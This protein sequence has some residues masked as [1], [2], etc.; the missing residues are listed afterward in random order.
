VDP[1]RLPRTV[2]PSRYDLR[3][4]PDLVTHTFAGEETIALDVA[5]PTAEVVL[6]TSLSEGGMPN[7]LLEA[8]AC[9]RPILATDIP[10]NRAAVED[11]T[12]GFLVADE[13]RFEEAARR[14]ATDPELRSRQGGA[15]RA[16]M[17]AWPSP[18]DE[19]AAYAALYE[20]VL[21][22]R[23]PDAAS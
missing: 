1:Y 16:R 18:A 12:T 20:E 2:V 21:R 13:A 22:P 7:A 4:T 3:L 10:G 23:R 19:A 6:N 8:A 17:A 5:E 9:G 11:G 15:A 14:L